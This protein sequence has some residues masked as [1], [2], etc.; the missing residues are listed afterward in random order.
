[1]I[2]F[3]VKIFPLVAITVLAF[4][5]RNNHKRIAELERKV[6]DLEIEQIGKE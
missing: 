1:M 2:E 6:K 5:N 3:S 4:L